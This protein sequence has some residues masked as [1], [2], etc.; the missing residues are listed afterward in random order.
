MLDARCIDPNHWF[1]GGKRHIDHVR[2]AALPGGRLAVP[3]RNK[4][5]APV[6]DR[7][8]NRRVGGRTLFQVTIERRDARRAAQ[9]MVVVAVVPG[10]PNVVM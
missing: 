10:S 2:R 7:L 6:N 1:P 3:D 4:D 8:T 5:V 9:Q